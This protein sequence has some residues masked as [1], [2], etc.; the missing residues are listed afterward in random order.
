M[1]EYF[2]ILF[3]NITGIRLK[4][5]PCDS[6][7]SLEREQELLS[8]GYEKVT[9]NDWDLIVG[10]I[11]GTPYAKNLNGEG[12]VP[13]QLPEPSLQEVKE[14]KIE[15]FKGN[16][17]KEEILPITVNN[18]SFDY[19]E[20]ARDRISAAIIALEGQDPIY[21]TTAD[22]QNVLVSANDLKDVVRA[23]AVR[24]NTLHVKYRQLKEQVMNATTIEEVD[25]INWND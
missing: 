16:R 11:D 8:Q 14:L 5:I 1:A 12:Y 6:D 18:N 13:I 10:N 19:D 7:L 9:K 24:S 17:D 2:L 23:V 3:D 4:T 25:E 22:N 21:W 20:K 15:L